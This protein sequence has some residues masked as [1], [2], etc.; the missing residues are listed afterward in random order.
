MVAHI[1]LSLMLI[2]IEDIQEILKLEAR[3]IWFLPKQELKK[4]F[5]VTELHFLLR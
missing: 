1:P 3:E 5:L 4:T 2:L